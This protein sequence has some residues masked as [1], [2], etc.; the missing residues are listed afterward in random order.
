LTV[1]EPESLFQLRPGSLGFYNTAY[2]YPWGLDCRIP[3]VQYSMMASIEDK[4]KEVYLVCENSEGVV[5]A[6]KPP[7]VLQTAF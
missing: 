7:P 1:S 6:L 2:T 5:Q 3:A 4:Q